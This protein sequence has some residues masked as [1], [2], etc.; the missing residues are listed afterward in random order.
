MKREEIG[1]WRGRSR[2]QQR[3]LGEEGGVSNSR[4]YRERRGRDSERTGR[5]S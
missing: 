5:G 4:V 1:R 2:D 3:K